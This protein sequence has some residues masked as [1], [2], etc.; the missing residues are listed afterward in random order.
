[1]TLVG[2]AVTLKAVPT[3]YVTVVDRLSPPLVP[4]TVTVNVVDVTL[5]VQD[6]VEVPEEEVVV[7]EMLVVPRLQVRPD[8]GRMV[9]VRLTI[10]VNP[11]AL[12]TVTVDV[13]P[14][15]EKTKTLVG[16]APTVKSWTEYVTLAE[17]LREDPVPVTVTV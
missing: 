3:L 5:G 14:V 15:P 6:S 10:P 11:L 4:I 1:M 8:E 9:S 7:S 17:W 13:P 12:E 2:L 16:L